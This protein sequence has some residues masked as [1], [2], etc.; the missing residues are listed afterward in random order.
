MHI[1]LGSL[2]PQNGFAAGLAFVEHKDFTDEWRL[3]F[4]TDA[5][6]TPNGSWRAG[7]YLS[8]YKL[9]QSSKVIGIVMGTPPPSQEK[10]TFQVAPIF[11]PLC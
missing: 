3:T 2:A 10:P 11:K 9:P 8:T 7:S 5:V 6:T 4:D 1:A